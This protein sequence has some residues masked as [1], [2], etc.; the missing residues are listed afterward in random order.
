[1]P[2]QNVRDDLSVQDIEGLDWGDPGGGATGLVQ[3]VLRWRRTPLRDLGAEGL[4]ELIG[5]QV[6]LELLVPRAI[7]A[8]ERDPRTAGDLYP[9]DLL[10]AVLAAG[11][12]WSAHPEQRPRME[13]ILTALDPTDGVDLG[14][15]IAVF[16]AARPPTPS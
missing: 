6:S 15:D 10:S 5:Q 13:R 14:P 4:R 7:T 12:Y 9:G 1:M 2:E 11:S 8:L 3:N 16:R